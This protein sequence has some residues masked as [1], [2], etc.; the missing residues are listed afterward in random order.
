MPPQQRTAPKAKHP[1]VS[2]M[3]ELETDVSPCRKTNI[4][5][6]FP[7]FCLLPC[8]HTSVSFFLVLVFSLRIGS[9]FCFSSGHMAM[10]KMPP[11]RER[12][13]DLLS[14]PMGLTEAQW[15]SAVTWGAAVQADLLGYVLDR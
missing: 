5:E 6:L 8:S 15:L 14:S 4:I 13:V 12:T 10:D 9:N 11:E 1:D 3:C 7:F 2:I